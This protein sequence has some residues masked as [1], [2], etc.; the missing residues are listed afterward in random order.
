[1]DIHF[2]G[3]HKMQMKTVILA[4]FGLFTF[5]S[6]LVIMTAIGIVSYQ[7][8]LKSVYKYI[9]RAENQSNEPRLIK[10][11]S[12]LLALIIFWAAFM[13]VGSCLIVIVIGKYSNVPWLM[14][15]DN[16]WFGIIFISVV[17]LGIVAAV[18]SPVLYYLLKI[19]E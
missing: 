6:F 15:I 19:E 12:S 7:A 2:H 17:I 8:K 3:I 1:M 14:Q 5:G 10:R 16:A 9:N 11:P 13:C 4:L 18:V